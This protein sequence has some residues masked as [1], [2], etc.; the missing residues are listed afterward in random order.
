MEKNTILAIVLSVVVVVG[1]TIVQGIFF[2]PEPLAPAPT[3]VTANQPL[4]Q[5]S[6]PVLGAVSENAGSGIQAVAGTITDAATDS[7]NIAEEHI[8]IDTDLVTIVFSNK[9]G[10]IVSYK[11]KEHNDKDNLVEMVLPGTAEAHAFTVAFGDYNAQPIQNLFSVNRVSPTVIEFSRD[12][13]IA[14]ANGEAGQFRLIKRYEL[15]PD[16]Y[17][18]QLSIAIDGGSM[19]PQLSNSN[20]AYTL[21]FGP[22]IGPAFE[23]LDQRYEY[24][25][26]LTYR[27]SKRREERV[28]GTKTID[29][30]TKWAAIAGKYFTVIALPDNVPV[31]Y[32]FSTQAEPGLSDASRLFMTRPSLSGSK[33]ID[34]YRFYIGPKNQN[35]LA[36]YD[37]ADNQLKL[38]GTGI[39]AV[40]SSSGFWAPLETALKWLLQLFYKV[41]P[42]WGVAIILL[43]LFVKLVF[44]PLTKKSSETTLRM[45]ALAPKVKEI[46]EKYKE[47]PQKLNAEMAALYKKEGANPVAG[48]LPMLLQLPIFFAMY[49]LFNNHFDLRGAMFIPGWIPDL[50]LPESI[51]N[52]SPVTLPI[53]GWS[54]IR[55]LP[56]IYV[57]SQLLYG[58]ITQTPDQKGNTQMK[59]MLY[60]MPIMF[61]FILYNVPS[62]LLVYWIM[63]NVLT[64]FQQLIINKYIAKKK[65]AIA[66]VEEKDN[67]IAPPR[68]KK[69]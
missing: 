23:K 32:T 22:Q 2:T 47:N 65:A 30:D 67:V 57:G 5:E 63:S 55:L 36:I 9:G 44:F 21:G 17:L 68:K 41:I 37:N 34:T 10:D 39:N 66:T 62:G 45:Q 14:T 4:I 46:Q 69:K 27:D 61:F 1:W 35:D 56:F 54:D 20:I 26:Y 43:T 8:T 58:K 28:T 25:H 15:I 38:Q 48:C 42:N 7:E 50:S 24:R 3:S 16:E 59:M 18:F 6:S 31:T 51:W 49:N 52:F 19:I 13:S 60:V 29:Y 53:L 12:F 64:L 33:T 11:L 40:A